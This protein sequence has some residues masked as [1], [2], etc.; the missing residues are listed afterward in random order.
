[1]AFEWGAVV[2]NIILTF[3]V[4][5]VG[6]AVAIGLTA[7]DVP[8]MGVTVGAAAFGLLGPLVLWPISFTLWQALDL[9]MRP[10]SP[11]ERAGHTATHL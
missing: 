10:P 2:V 5:L 11:A 8:V 7:P 1:M 9:I 4:I 6:L 3:G